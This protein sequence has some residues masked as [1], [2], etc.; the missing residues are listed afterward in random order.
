[1]MHSAGTEGAERLSHSPK[2]TQ[3]MGDKAGESGSKLLLIATKFYSK[4]YRQPAIE[5]II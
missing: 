5:N 4:N 3:L 2:V 1:M